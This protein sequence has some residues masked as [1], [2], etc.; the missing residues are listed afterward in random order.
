[1]CSHVLRKSLPNTP[2][3]RFVATT[4]HRLLP[5]VYCC[6]PVL[7]QLGNVLIKASAGPNNHGKFEIEYRRETMIGSLKKLIKTIPELTHLF[8]DTPKHEALAGVR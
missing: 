3:S 5:C 2:V 6:L 8:P 7:L 1:M 4:R